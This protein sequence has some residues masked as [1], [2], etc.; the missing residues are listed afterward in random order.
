MD[1][2]TRIWLYRKMR[3]IRAFEEAS[4]PR[5]QRPGRGSHHP[6]IGQEAIEAAMG[7]VLRETDYL[8]GSHRSHGHLLAKG[9]DPKRMMAEL[10]GKETG[11]CHG[12][13]G[14]MH[15]TDWSKRVLPSGLV[16]TSV[17]LA[18]GAALAARMRGT[19]DVAMASIGDGGVNTGAFHEGLNLAA[20][21]RLPVVVV[22]ENNG[23][24]V[25]TRTQDSCPLACLS[26]RAAGYG[27]PGRTVDGTDPDAC[28]LALVEAV[29]R[30]RSGGGPS[31]VEATC[32]RWRGHAGW[33]RGSYLTED[34]I[35]AIA[36]A[37]PLPP[38]RRRLVEEGVLSEPEVDAIDSEMAAIMAE[39]V[40]FADESLDPPA[41]KE[42][43]VRYAYVEAQGR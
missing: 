27:I 21:W 1:S 15:I 43:A 18:A 31:F 30:A 25:S 37:D 14:S 38:Y 19:D 36:A 41:T 42:E 4:L 26:D 8:F 2:A 33:D 7:A 10:W 29:S 6:C 3:E 13:G 17:P 22:C 40:R 28:Y 39:A 34:E 9:L 23:I 12:R 16:G 32:R 11:Y 5:F 35:A 20:L 24:A